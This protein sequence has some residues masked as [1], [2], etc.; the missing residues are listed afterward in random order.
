MPVPS[1]AA[2]KIVLLLFIFL[3]PAVC[4]K[5]WQRGEKSALSAATACNHQDFLFV[6]SGKMYTAPAE[7]LCAMMMMMRTAS[8]FTGAAPF[9]PKLLVIRA[10]TSLFCEPRQF[11]DFIAL[12][13]EPS[14]ERRDLGADEK[15]KWLSRCKNCFKKPSTSHDERVEMSLRGA[16]KMRKS[17]ADL[18]LTY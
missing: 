8:S 4:A 7:S 13:A 16:E 2:L 3:W 17:F 10:R 6:L 18:R 9:N 15:K 11:F 14:K 5:K 1:E 12:V